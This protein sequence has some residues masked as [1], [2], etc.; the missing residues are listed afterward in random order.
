MSIC[1]TWILQ[2]LAVFGL[3]FKTLGQLC[4][5]SQSAHSSYSY[6]DITN[7]TA[8]TKLQGIARREWQAR[9]IS[10]QVQYVEDVCLIMKVNLICV[11]NNHIP[12]AL[13]C[14]AR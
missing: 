1:F 5:N 3:D 2:L 7:Y 8:I 14:D 4:S 10:L 12:P 11:V 13:V 6:S 9:N